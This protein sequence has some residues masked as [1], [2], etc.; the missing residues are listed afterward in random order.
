MKLDDLLKKCLKFATQIAN[1]TDNGYIWR[2][3][4]ELELELLE[5]LNIDRDTYVE[6][7]IGN[8]AS[9]MI[10]TITHN[11]DFKKNENIQQN[12]RI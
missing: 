7:N 6:E 12:N 10:H 1:T 5:H 4:C 11:L 2:E 8:Y 9:R 3:A